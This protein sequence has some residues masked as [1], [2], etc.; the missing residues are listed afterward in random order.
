MRK[1][2][3]V[4]LAI[5]ILL[6]SFGSVFAWEGGNWNVVSLSPGLIGNGFT[7][8]G[9]TDMSTGILAIP[10]NYALTKK[11]YSDGSNESGT[12][13]DGIR[14]QII[15]VVI[16]CHNSSGSFIITPT[17]KTGYTTVT[18]DNYGDSVTFLFLNST[19]GWVIIGSNGASIS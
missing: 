16:D 1:R 15:H 10:L 6:S 18:L 8:G 3:S 19:N 14:G 2:L 17:T 9:A 13:A 11:T 12:L 7:G 4:I 5:A